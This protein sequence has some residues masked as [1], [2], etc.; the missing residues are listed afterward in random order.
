MIPSDVYQEGYN[1][2]N[3]QTGTFYIILYISSLITV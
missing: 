2:C 1:I 3:N